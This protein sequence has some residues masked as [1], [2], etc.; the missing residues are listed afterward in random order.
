MNPW[1]FETG[2][3]TPPVSTLFFETGF[4]TPPCFNFGTGKTGLRFR[5]VSDPVSFEIAKTGLFETAQTGRTV[6]IVSEIAESSWLR[7]VPWSST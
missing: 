1:S 6:K 3:K 2:F 7:E 5:P 4:K